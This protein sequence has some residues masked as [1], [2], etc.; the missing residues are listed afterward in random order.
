MAKKSVGVIA[1][2]GMGSFG[3]DKPQS[4]AKP[5]YSEKLHDKV[6]TAFGAPQFDKQVA[7]G[8]IF[9]ADI[10]QQNQSAYL[11]RV[12]GKVSTGQI[13]DFVVNNLGDPASYSA[14]PY[15]D[16]NTV[17]LPVRER[18]SKAMKRMEGL[19]EPGAPVIMLAHSLGGHVISNHLWDSQHPD[20]AINAGVAFPMADRIAALVTFGCNI[21][22]FTFALAFGDI[23]AI[24]RPSAGLAKAK[25]LTP[26]WHNFYDFDDVLG[27]P[28]AATGK[29]YQARAKAG[30]L[31]DHAINAGSLFTSWNAFS[32]TGYWGDDD[33]ARPVADLLRQI[34]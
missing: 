4:V 31:V 12:A 1:V 24:A 5:S 34:A 33:L 30:E 7:W 6:R 18:I 14:N 15:S 2:H 23:A 9:Y 8:E 3:P 20:K 29:G 10:L 25:R 13:R 17:Y 11:A 26:W 32:H 21:P 19:L 28:L 16:K 22:L 27:F